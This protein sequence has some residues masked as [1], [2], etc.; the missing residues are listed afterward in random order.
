MMA[1]L[2]GKEK[3]ADIVLDLLFH[4]TRSGHIIIFSSAVGRRHALLPRR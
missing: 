1:N 2:I 3:P 4:R